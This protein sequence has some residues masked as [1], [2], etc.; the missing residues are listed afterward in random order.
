MKERA[1][2][3]HDF[4]G[5]LCA[6]SKGCTWLKKFLFNHLLVL[7]AFA[8]VAYCTLLLWRETGAQS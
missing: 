8:A 6:L 1:A 5:T 4:R 3:F 2:N 7:V